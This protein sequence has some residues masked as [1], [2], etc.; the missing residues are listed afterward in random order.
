MVYPGLWHFR[1]TWKGTTGI[2]TLHPASVSSENTRSH[3]EDYN[4]L[5]IFNPLAP[6][7]A[8]EAH[9]GS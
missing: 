7:L 5:N 4:G 8:K 6:V 1:L 3:G 9:A 2:L